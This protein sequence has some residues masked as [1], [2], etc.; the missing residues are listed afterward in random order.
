GCARRPGLE[1]ADRS[2]PQIP[3][4]VRCYLSLPLFFNPGLRE[5]ADAR[6]R[7]VHLPEGPR[8]RNREEIAPPG[9]DLGGLRR[10]PRLDF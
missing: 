9:N 2:R 5:R 4:A 1:S 7:S 8:N 6:P 3:V 10:Q